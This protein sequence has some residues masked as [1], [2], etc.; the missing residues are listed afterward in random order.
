ME[1]KKYFFKLI[2]VVFCIL[3]VISSGYVFNKS[4]DQQQRDTASSSLKLSTDFIRADKGQPVSNSERQAATDE[5]I[6]LIK[7][8][9]Y[10]DFVDSR[11][12]GMPENEISKN[13]SWAHW[14]TGVKVEKHNGQVSF[15]HQNNGSDN[16][17]IQTAPYLEGACF[18]FLLTGDKKY[19]NLARQ[20]MR[21]MS[22]WILS[23]SRSSQES[24]KI[25]SRSFYPPSVQSSASGKN[26]L[27][28]Y[29]ASR[30][31]L[32]AETSSYVHVPNN[33]FFGDVWLKNNRSIDDIGH[34]L[35]A[36][37]QVQACSEKF[38]DDA[39]ADLRQ[40]TL[41]YAEWASTVA[42]NNFIIPTMDL[43]ANMQIIKNGLGDYNKY[44]FLNSDP[45]CI[46]KLAVQYTYSS[47][48]HNLN[49]GNGIS[50]IEKIGGRFL[51]NDAIEILRSHHVAAAAFAQ[52]R[53]QSEPANRLML[54]L[55][56]RMDRDFKVINNPS[57]SP[58]FDVQDI[59]TFF[60]H[61]NNVGVPMT[62]DEL[63]YLYQRLHLAH[64]GMRASVYNQ[65]YHLFEASTP[66]GVYSYDPPHIGLYFYT[67]GAMIGSCTS[68]FVNMKDT[69]R[70]LLDC[71]LLKNAF[72][73]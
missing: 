67:L 11:I 37:S 60:V 8:T 3:S 50:V 46:E 51:Q 57:L 58:Q 28:N 23:S 62:S 33:P 17:G 61:S 21:G 39:K 30:P 14:W 26:I 18:A 73:K 34:I 41:L 7:D 16:V 43:N 70:S 53:L 25:L 49:C 42:E 69:Q 27:I 63:R 13:N 52:L 38:D 56:E 15:T 71:D 44:S 12:H 32:N 36:I 65:T 5:F 40:L 55:S 45:A 54:G 47:D 22:S 72:V 59:A 9:N 20:L 24:P 6:D 4:Q 48:V 29:D 19:S 35:R 1:Q 31:G 68:Q 10:F 2:A 66:D 64:E